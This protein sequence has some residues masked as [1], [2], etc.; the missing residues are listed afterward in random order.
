MSSD[1]VPAGST[2][3]ACEKRAPQTC[4]H[5]TRQI[6][7]SGSTESI[8]KLPQRS[9]RAPCTLCRD[10]LSR[11]GDRQ[12]LE[13]LRVCQSGAGCRID[14]SSSARLRAEWSSRRNG[15][16]DENSGTR[17][18]SLARTRERPRETTRKNIR[19]S[20]HPDSSMWPATC[21]RTL[22][23]TEHRGLRAPLCS[24]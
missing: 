3:M 5:D 20:V 23:A 2:R 4:S 24:L 15:R 16:M 18:L 19:S 11:P 8:A 17:R 9:L 6:V 21:S 7:W 12:T 10:F 13:S 1:R 22:V 14:R